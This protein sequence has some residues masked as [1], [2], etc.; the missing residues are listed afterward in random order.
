MFSLRNFPSLASIFSAYASM[1]GYVMMIKQFVEMTIPPPLQNYIITYL[2]CYFVSTPST[3]TLIIESQIKNGMCNELYEAAQVYLSTKINRDA[4]R[5]RI[6]RHHSEKNVKLYLSN[7]E[8]VSDVYQG[9]ELKWR[10]IVVNS[11]KSNM[12]D[13]CFELSFEKKLRDFVLNSY[14]PYVERKA[15]VINDE[16]RILKMHSYCNR[17]LTWQSVKLEHPTTFETMAMNKELKRSVVEDLDKFIKRKDFYKRV[18]KAWKRGYLLYGPHGTGKTSLVAAMAKHLKFDIYDLQL[19]SVKGEADL[20]RLL[21]RT[22]NSSILV[23]ED[24]DCFMDL[25]TR[26]QPMSHDDSKGTE[27]LTLTGILN[28]I[29]GL[30]S[31]CGDERIVIFT[32]NHKERLDP[33]LLR[34]GRMDMHIHMGHC[35]FD[36]FKTL[37]SNYLGLSHDENHYLYPEIKRLISGEVLTPAQ[38]SEELMKNE[39]IDMALEGLVRALKKKRAEQEKYDDDI[40]KNMEKLEEGEET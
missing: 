11:E 20:R 6:S 31:S 2:N 39:D 1:S 5:L 28:C 29:D 15:K 32:T 24:I 14:V 12:V 25:P 17:S 4:S 9:I 27:T 26:L 18:G 23:V 19:A 30:W 21:L 8:H 35:C 38:V 7:G 34:P 3:L 13:E 22:K 37:A 36:G 10:F 33:E 16:R 40:K